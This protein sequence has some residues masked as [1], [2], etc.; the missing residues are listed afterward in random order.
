MLDEFQ[1]LN[2]STDNHYNKWDD[3]RYYIT[4]PETTFIEEIDTFHI[5]R[6]KGFKSNIFNIVIKNFTDNVELQN[7]MKTYI[8]SKINSLK[9]ANTILNQIRF[10]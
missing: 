6:Y 2:L 10:E 4:I 9:P 8:I 5:N 1:I 3:M 7:L